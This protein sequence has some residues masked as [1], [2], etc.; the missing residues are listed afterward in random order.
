MRGH[1]TK[2]QAQRSQFKRAVIGNG[3]VMLAA[4]PGRHPQVA[5]GLPRDFVA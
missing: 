5:A 4:L 1:V 3:D 2:I